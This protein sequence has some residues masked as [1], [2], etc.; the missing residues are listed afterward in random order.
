MD[1][2]FEIRYMVD[3]GCTHDKDFAVVIAKD[4][5]KAEEYLRKHIDSLGYD[6]CIH[7]ILSINEIKE[8]IVVTGKY[9]SMLNN[10]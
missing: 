10:K 8:E 9:G 7:K 2:I 5:L 1:K 3:N 4:E 6:Y